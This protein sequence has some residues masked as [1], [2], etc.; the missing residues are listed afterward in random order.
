M[1]IDDTIYDYSAFVKKVI[2]DGFEKYGLC[3]YSDGLYEVYKDINNQL[4]QSADLRQMPV[5]E[6]NSI[7]W[8]RFFKEI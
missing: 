4:W 8:N 7:C 1:D 3:P 2:K 6:L 5:P